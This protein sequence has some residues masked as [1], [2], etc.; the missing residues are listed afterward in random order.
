MIVWHH[1]AW[2]GIAYRENA[3]VEQ[4]ACVLGDAAEDQSKRILLPACGPRPGTGSCDTL[5]SA[6]IQPSQSPSLLLVFDAAFDGGEFKFLSP[7]IFWCSTNY[8]GL[9]S[10]HRATGL[11]RSTSCSWKRPEHTAW[12]TSGACLP[13]TSRLVLVTSAVRTTEI[14]SFPGA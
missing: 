10:R 4:C 1:N 9:V 8:L 5:A 3:W 6:L 2:P 13:R 12:V 7:H 14:P 11:R